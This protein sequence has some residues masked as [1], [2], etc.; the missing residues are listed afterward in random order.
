MHLANEDRL[1]SALSPA[2]RQVLAD[3][4][5]GSS[6][7][8]SRPP[9]TWRPRGLVLEQARLA[10]ARRQAVGLS[11]QPGLLVASVLPGSPAHAAGME[12]GDLL[13]TLDGAEVISSTGLALQLETWQ[14]EGR[15]GHRTAQAGLL[16]GNKA[17]TVELA[18]PPPDR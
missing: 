4:L 12:R 9:P 2:E 8:S 3:L 10:R 17:M 1:L 13:I 7:R 18:L 5:R 14:L 15:L 11:D 16:R 6:P